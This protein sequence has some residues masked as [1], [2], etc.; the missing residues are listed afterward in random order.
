MNWIVGE[1]ERRGGEVSFRD[2]MEL[3]L[4]HPSRGFYS[5]PEPR[6]GRAGDFLTA[7]TASAWYAIVLGGWLE[8]LAT[9]IGPVGVIDVASGDGSLI[10]ALVDV[11]ARRGGGWMREVVSVERSAAMRAVQQQRLAGSSRVPIRVAASTAE[12]API[13]GPVVLHACELYD[14]LPVHRV[15]MRHHG[16]QE[17]RVGIDS[18]A[19]SWREGPAPAE[20]ERYFAGHGVRLEPG[21]IAEA[22]LEA[23]GVHRGLLGL[24][25]AGGLAVVLDY[26][27][28]S[29]RLYDPRG[30]AGGSLV[31]YRS[32][33]LS[34]D[35]LA[36]PGE[37]D[38]TCHVNWDDLRRAGSAAG[39]RE[40]A[41]VPLATFLVAAGLAAEMERLDVG[42]EA[43][44]DARTVSE[45]Q[46]IKRLLDPDGMGADLKV[47]I[48]GFGAVADA[49]ED[50]LED[51]R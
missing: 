11:D 7:P 23:E 6:Y 31:A 42:V 34:R 9:R 25:S 22:C 14:S 48:Q 39:W 43:E 10:A 5:A 37:W 20:L 15:V 46:E 1:I 36:D 40:L 18:G 26:G 30:R 21:Q 41:L 12:L 35:P 47:L 44:L 50:L 49:A 27:Y 19:C 4:Y 24:A 3:A 13:G 45:R 32:H 2:F 38:L 28:E 33:R 51:L 29:S 8:R 16:L 17:L